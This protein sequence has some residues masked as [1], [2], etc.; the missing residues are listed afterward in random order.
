[1]RGTNKTPTKVNLLAVALITTCIIVSTSLIGLTTTRATVGGVDN[2]DLPIGN[3]RQVPLDIKI[4]FIGIKQQ[5]I[6]ITDGYFNWTLPPYHIQRE[7]WYGTNWGVNYTFNYS[8]SLNQTFDDDFFNYIHF[9][10]GVR[11]DVL[12]LTNPYN[13]LGGTYRFY[14]ANK[15]DDWLYS[16]PQGYGGFP[17]RDT[18][19]S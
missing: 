9:G 4:V 15:V 17:Q 12:G 14:N 5:Y 19:F 11:K 8:Y 6:N 18:H 10:A 2:E 1:M 3:M 13:G 7:T 16:N